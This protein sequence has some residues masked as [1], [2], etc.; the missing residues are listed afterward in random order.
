VEV[1]GEALDGTYSSDIG[2]YVVACNAGGSK[3]GLTYNFS[4]AEITVTLE[5]L[6]FALTTDDGS[7]ATFNDGTLACALGIN[8]STDDSSPMI[9]GDTFLRNAYVVYDLD[10]FEVSLAN[11]VLDSSD[12]SIEAIQ[13]T[14]PSATAAASYSSTQ[15]ATQVNVQTP[16]GLTFSDVG[17]YAGGGA[18][19]VSGTLA[20]GSNVLS[21]IQTALSVPTTNSLQVNTATGSSTAQSS[22]SSTGSKKNA[23]TTLKLSG[24]CLGL[25]MIGALLI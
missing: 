17:T 23:G 16:T 9:L 20:T 4:G 24:A 2:F 18:S 19:S 13:S 1:I 5:Q 11:A 15:L 21:S 12:S 22:S 3:G 6:M 25:M 8:P 10:D 14:V 7:P